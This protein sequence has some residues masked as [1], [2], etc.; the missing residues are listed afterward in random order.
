MRNLLYKRPLLSSICINLIFLLV[1]IL[2]IKYDLIILFKITI[3][4]IWVNINRKMVINQ[5]GVSKKNTIFIIVN[6]I[7]TILIV[8]VYNYYTVITRVINTI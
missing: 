2:L 1:C 4:I 5:R 7:I 6:A 8:L 3:F